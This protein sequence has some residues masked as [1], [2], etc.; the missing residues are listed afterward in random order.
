M[1][2]LAGIWTSRMGDEELV[3]RQGDEELVRLSARGDKEA[4]RV[5]VEKYQARAFGLALGILKNKEDAE[6]VLQ[7][8]FVKAYLSIPQFKGDSAFYTWFYRIVVNMAIDLKRKKGRSGG[9]PKELNE[10]IEN[11]DVGLGEIG[12]FGPQEALLR[13]ET[14]TQIQ[15]ALN[16]LSPEH[17]TVIV[18]REV[19]GLSYEEIADVVQVSR[20]TVMSRLHYARKRVQQALQRLWATEGEQKNQKEEY[21]YG[22]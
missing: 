3:T 2:L 19:D 12:G 13:K 6:D 7:E 5:L 1:S 21:A 22:R 15:Q 11:G 18:L 8:S 9:D 10:E 16:E 14:A 20:G 4:Y 17:R